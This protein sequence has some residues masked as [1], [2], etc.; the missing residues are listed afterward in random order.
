MMGFGVG[1]GISVGVGLGLWV[2]DAWLAGVSLA[3]VVTIAIS[4]GVDVAFATRMVGVARPVKNITAA[5]KV[6]SRSMLLMN[7]P[8]K[9][10]NE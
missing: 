7:K 10:L 4:V 3:R 5:S 8:K 1:R 2:G 9:N 6:A